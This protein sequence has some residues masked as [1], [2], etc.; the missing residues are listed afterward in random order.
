MAG[1]IY[2]STLSSARECSWEKEPDRLHS[3]GRR[4][5]LAAPGPKPSS[6]L[7]GQTLAQLQRELCPPVSQDVTNLFWSIIDSM[8]LAGAPPCQ[9]A[10]LPEQPWCFR[11]PTS[12]NSRPP[13]SRRVR[14]PGISHCFTC[15][16]LSQ[17][18]VQP[19]ESRTSSNGMWLHKLSSPLTTDTNPCQRFQQRNAL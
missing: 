7:P 6:S 13:A 1:S 4:W 3:R 8:V 14:Q 2:P 16:C 19:L 5:S 17:S 9:L 15:K 11:A 10:P 18:K 12:P